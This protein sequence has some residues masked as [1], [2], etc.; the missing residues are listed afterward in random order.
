MSFA[1]AARRLATMLATVAGDRTADRLWEREAEL[2]AIERVLTGA[3][4]GAGS[5]L[6][7]SGVAGIGKSVLLDRAAAQ[8]R[9]RGLGVLT[10]AGGV[11]E[12][13]YAFGVALQLLDRLAG[14]PGQLAVLLAG[15]G[16]AAAPVLA[17][18]AAVVRPPDASFAVLH[19]L[20]WAVANLAA[21]QPL[22]ICVDDAQWCDEPSLLFLDFVARRLDDLPIALITAVRSGEPSARG[23]RALDELSGGS[24]LPVVEPA[25][26]SADAVFELTRA[27]FGAEAEESFASVCHGRTGGNPFFATELLREMA[28]ENV[29]P[30]AEEARRLTTGAPVAVGRV[31]LARLMRLGSDAAAL[32]RAVA[33]LGDHALVSDAAELA[34]MS[35]AAATT[36]AQALVTAAIFGPGER[37]GFSHPLMRDAVNADVSATVLAERHLQAARVLD[38]HDRDPELIAAHLLASPPSANGRAVLRLRSAAQIALGRGAPEEAATLLG[39][40]LAEPPSPEVASGVLFDLGIAEAAAMRPSAIEHL[41]S[42]YASAADGPERANVALVLAGL[43]MFAGLWRDIYPLV[44]DTQAQLGASERELSLALEAVALTASSM[45]PTGPRLSPDRIAELSRLT[46][47][48]PAECSVLVCTAFELGKAA[49]PIDVV[50]ALAERANAGGASKLATASVLSSPFMLSTILQWSGQIARSQELVTALID[51]A[52]TAGSPLLFTEACSFRGTTAWRGGSLADAEA[53]ARQALAT[54]GPTSD[55]TSPFASSCLLRTLTDRG[56]FD[57]ALRIS[58]LTDLRPDRNDTVMTGVID[59][60]LGRLEIAMRQ[61]EPALVR[62]TA[63]GEIVEAAG[64]ANPAAS[65]WRVDAAHALVGMGRRDEARELLAP[66]MAASRRSSGPYELGI[67]LRAAALVERPSNLELLQ[68]S[69]AQLGPS[70]LR[71]EY[72]RSL[73]E[74]GAAL[75]R[76]GHRQDARG[77]LAEGMDL[78]HRCGA[79]PLVDR[80][81][82]ELLAA[83]ARPRRVE[84]TGVDALTPS[85]RRTASLA[86]EGLSNRE[87]AQQ[88]F[89]SSRTVES[90][91]RSAYQKLGLSSRQELADALGA[92]PSAP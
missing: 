77:P 84:R 34:G 40:A 10:A 90:Q 53:D 79:T 12:R 31:V 39:R 56:L 23:S 50:L 28:E 75:R 92:A 86:R 71:L 66:A 47:A 43:L 16:A 11:L 29:R 58:T 35:R 44:A 85:E 26:L 57:E 69:C 54:A 36:A 18:S 5:G 81:R 22:L 19:G 52:R 45:D 72:A 62:L 20:F 88:L 55:V 74:L 42:A 37:L 14:D 91:L 24:V 2:S 51:E 76:S 15:A 59:V 64:T 25:P 1:T 17:P 89:V 48:T 38:A 27:I 87:I 73:V 3:L 6:L 33:V 8:A 9:G 46:G 65:E 49:H 67:T 78:A 82:K 4:S 60:S 80:A 41:Q 83:G 32:A 70:E 7:L 68:E 13:E 30:T 63:A 61:Y 21:Q